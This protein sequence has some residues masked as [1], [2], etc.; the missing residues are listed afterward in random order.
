MKCKRIQELILT[1]YV[2]DQLSGEWRQFVDDHLTNCPHCR[3]FAQAVKATVQPFS[4]AEK[5]NPPEDL[6]PRIKQAIEAERIS[7]ETEWI[8]TFIR[9]LTHVFSVPKAVLAMMVMLIIMASVSTVVI[10]N[11]VSN[12]NASEQMDYLVSLVQ[13]SGA[14]AVSEE[15]GLETFIE[16]YFL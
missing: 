11:A 3:K 16:Q 6:W 13:P 7:A 1:D 12:K 14:S 10:R 15:E 8:E 2:D 9:N 5:M 4:Q